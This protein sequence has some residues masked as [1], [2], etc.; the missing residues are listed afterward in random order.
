MLQRKPRFH[1]EAAMANVKDIIA[2]IEELD[3]E[4]EEEMQKLRLAI[5]QL[6]RQL[7]EAQDEAEKWKNIASQPK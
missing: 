3:K 2:S 7:K 1:K 4:K 6:Q 5:F